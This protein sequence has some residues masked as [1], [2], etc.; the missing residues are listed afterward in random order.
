MSSD[1]VVGGVIGGILALIAIWLLIGWLDK[2]FKP[3][4]NEHMLPVSVAGSAPNT[5]FQARIQP[6]VVARARLQPL[7]QQEILDRILSSSAAAPEVVAT[8][9]NNAPSASSSSSSLTL[10]V[11]A[12]ERL[13]SNGGEAQPS[14]TNISMTR[15]G[16]VV[17]EWGPTVAATVPHEMAD[18]RPQVVRPKDGDATRAMV[19]RDSGAR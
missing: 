14:S 1:G 15:D 16:F 18:H 2:C 6:P 7:T 17:M 3:T 10:P 4:D 19:Q 8:T 5:A 12:P 11:D 9:A 13:N